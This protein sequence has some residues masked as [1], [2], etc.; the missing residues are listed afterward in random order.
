[1]QIKSNYIDISNKEIYSAKITI[2][3]GKI[4][5]IEKINE[6]LDTYIFP[7]FVDA[8]VHIES[9]M[10]VPTEFAKKAVIHGTVATVSDP[11]EI[12]NVLGKEG[13]YYMIENGKK[14]PFK[15]NFG[16]PSCVP[17]TKFETAGAEVTVEDIDELMA[18]EEIKYLAEMMNYPGV[19]FQDKMV[20]DKIAVAKKYN[21]PVDGHA[22]GLSG[23][24][25]IQYIS[26]GISTDHEC[27]TYEEAKFKLDHGMK[28]LI[29][30]GSAAKNFEALIDLLNDYP[31]DIMFCSDDKHPDDLL[32]GHVNLLVKRA[33]AKGNDLFKVL[34]A[35]CI[36]PILHY[37][38]NVGLLREND[39]A[40][41]IIINNPDDFDILETYI[42]GNLV[43]KNGTSFIET[44]PEKIV[45][46]FDIDFKDA[47]DFKIQLAHT[48][49]KV[50][51]VIDGQLITKTHIGNIVLDAE[52]NAVSNMED[53]ILKVAVINRY[54]DTPVAVAF[55]KN[56]GL[57][58]GAL[59]SSVAHDSHNIIVVGADDES[60]SKAANA[61]IEERGG[62]SV[63]D[64]AITKILGL[65]V[66]GLMSTDSC[67]VVGE[68]Y[69]ELVKFA[70]EIGCTLH[71][72]FMS[73]SFMALLV[74]PQLKLSDK[75]LFDGEK[76]E[77]CDL[78]VKD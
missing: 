55:I 36:N 17:A 46:N 45:N 77:F 56:F 78:E 38:L 64:G 40:D 15:F 51:E 6:L 20:L 2:E 57:K 59:A 41:F 19:L 24:K 52:G 70:K 44:S 35:A 30:E 25:A 58:R 10:L 21:K 1:M 18:L 26:A 42:D 23:E 11:H 33:L 31:D 47:A 16:A 12:A 4:K 14:C 71:S 73:L 9:S 22:P 76:F 43:A 5:L 62:L 54:Y 61:I 28:V 74:I 68:K 63:T 65:P 75:G 27:F 60:M 67:E 48:K 66:A 8:H 53:D 49:V 69:T 3:N 34:Q 50:I 32:I 13:V 72:P 29:R 7:G 37:K 39:P